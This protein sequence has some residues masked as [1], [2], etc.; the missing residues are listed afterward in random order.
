MSEAS[1]PNPSQFIGT[2]LPP[3]EEDFI[4]IEEA[5]AIITHSL[6]PAGQLNDQHRNTVKYFVDGRPDLFVRLNEGESPDNLRVALQATQRLGQYGVNVLPAQL[7]DRSDAAYVVTKR[8]NG[9]SLDEV[10]ADNPPDEVVELAD[11]VWAGIAKYLFDSR[12]QGLPFCSDA[13]SP[14]Q[15]MLGTVEGES[16][17]K[18]WLTDLPTITFGKED[19]RFDAFAREVLVLVNDIVEIE[20]LSGK[21]LTLARESC[22][23]LVSKMADS[24]TLGNGLTNAA[25]RVLEQSETIF[26]GDVE[27]RLQEFKTG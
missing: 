11:G 16:I 2:P 5:E 19:D 10:L 3:P 1:L 4:S 15:F 17:P 9:R 13:T 7:V 14:G 6:I 26:P 21:K 23:E 12:E 24:A 22:S 18:I 20:K 25:K 27:E 8:V